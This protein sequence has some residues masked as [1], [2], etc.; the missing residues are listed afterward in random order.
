M[1]PLEVRQRVY[2]YL[3]RGAVFT[4]HLSII[5][6]C[7]PRSVLAILSVNRQCYAESQEVL[8]G[9][10]LFQ[11][12][13]PD[14]DKDPISGKAA[15]PALQLLKEEG[16]N[17]IYHPSSPHAYDELPAIQSLERV[18]TLRLVYEVSPDCAFIRSASKRQPFSKWLIQGIERG[19]QLPEAVDLFFGCCESGDVCTE[20]LQ[21]MDEGCRCR[22]FPERLRDHIRT[23]ARDCKA[24]IELDMNAHAHDVAYRMSSQ[25]M[26]EPYT[27]DDRPEPLVSDLS[28]FHRYIC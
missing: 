21:H 7:N 13:A 12:F 27:W 20:D 6:N 9:E 15:T 25:G 5:S 18:Q 28:I 8:F 3:F 14:L 17:I 4:R 22:G 16:R 26:N 1:L 19:F 24:T 2:Y 11:L 23:V 10:A